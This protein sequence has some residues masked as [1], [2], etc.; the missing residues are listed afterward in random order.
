MTVIQVA[1]LLLLQFCLKY[2][3]LT[4]KN[5][6]LTN[7]TRTFV[8]YMAIFQ[9]KLKIWMV[10]RFNAVLAK[11]KRQDIELLKVEVLVLLQLTA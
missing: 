2:Q 5:K 1:Q 8:A 7:T 4:Q 6:I 11:R 10:A 3:Y 9:E